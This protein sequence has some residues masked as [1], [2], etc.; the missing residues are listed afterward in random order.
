MLTQTGKTFLAVGAVALVLGIGLGYVT[1]MAVGIAFLL[2]VIV[3]RPVDCAA[4]ASR[5]QP[6]GCSRTGSGRSSR[7]QPADR[8]ESRSPSDKRRSCARTIW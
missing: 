8:F 5:R 2:I 7:E 1:L 3:G 6:I 4:S